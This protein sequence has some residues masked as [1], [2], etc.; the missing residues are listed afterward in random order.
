MRQA[1]LAC[2]LVD[3]FSHELPY[4]YFQQLF[5][6]LLDRPSFWPL[7]IAISIAPV[8]FPALLPWPGLL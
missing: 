5:L 4:F 3:L 8:L 6:Q 2:N 7:V 1:I